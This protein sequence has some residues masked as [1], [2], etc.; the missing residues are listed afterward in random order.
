MSFINLHRLS[1]FDRRTVGR[2]CGSDHR[3]HPAKHHIQR[4]LLDDALK[5]IQGFP[6]AV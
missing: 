4:I 3:E 1:C 5:V 6:N 2:L